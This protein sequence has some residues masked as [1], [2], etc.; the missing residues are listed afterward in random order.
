MGFAVRAGY[1]TI[2]RA[3]MVSLAKFVAIGSVLA[4]ALWGTARLATMQF[5]AMNS[6]RNEATLG[7]LIAVGA[8][9]YGTLVLL[10]FGR[11]WLRKLVRG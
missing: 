8:V 11:S 3:W 9:V 6:L 2:D 10:L 4:A 5:A 1:L 7:V